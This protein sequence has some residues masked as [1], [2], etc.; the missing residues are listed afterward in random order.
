MASLVVGYYLLG[1]GKGDIDY[2]YYRSRGWKDK[3]SA[4]P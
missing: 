1:I 3:A 2:V 4:E